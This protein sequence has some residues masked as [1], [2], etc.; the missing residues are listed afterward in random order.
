MNWYR[1]TTI[2][3]SSSKAG[4]HWTYYQ[5]A[6]TYAALRKKQY[7]KGK[8]IRMQ[9]KK[10]ARIMKG[11]LYVAPTTLQRMHKLDYSKDLKDKLEANKMRSALIRRQGYDVWFID[12]TQL[13]V[14]NPA[15]IDIIWEK[16]Q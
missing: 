7:G 9:L 14:A 1:G 16:V 3:D 5:I 4:T 10:D 15:A 6:K 2:N 11:K 12:K 13:F 8:L